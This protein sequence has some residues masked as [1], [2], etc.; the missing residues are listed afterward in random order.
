MPGF[1]TSF[2]QRASSAGAT[3]TSQGLERS[4]DADNGRR[5]S[6][7]SHWRCWR[8]GLSSRHDLSSRIDRVPREHIEKRAACRADQERSCIGFSHKTVNKPRP[9]HGH[10]RAVRRARNPAFTRLDRSGRNNISILRAVAPYP[11]ESW[12][13][14]HMRRREQDAHTFRQ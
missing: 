4:G 10:V 2:V 13:K 7:L 1:G 9:F 12:E 6:G 14:R 8:V 5:G 11:L 3:R